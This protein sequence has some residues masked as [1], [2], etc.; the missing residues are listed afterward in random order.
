MD[1]YPQ[2]K[3]TSSEPLDEAFR[4]WNE[5]LDAIDADLDA[6]YAAITSPE[7]VNIANK[8]ATFPPDAHAHGWT[9]ITGKPTSFAPSAH[10]HTYA[11]ITSKPATF[12]PSAHTHAQADVTGLPAK[13]TAYDAHVAST[14]IHRK[15]TTGTANPT[16]G[17]SGDIYLKHT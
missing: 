3:V 5:V 15:I 12:A 10:A 6:V 11:E 16:G 14:D 4:K 8:P 13:I 7:W 2:Q 17:V 1:R 9:D